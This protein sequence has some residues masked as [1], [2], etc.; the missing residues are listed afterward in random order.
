MASTIVGIN[1]GFLGNVEVVDSYQLD[2]W[3]SVVQVHET[4]RSYLD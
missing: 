4:S 1:F 3:L 2:F